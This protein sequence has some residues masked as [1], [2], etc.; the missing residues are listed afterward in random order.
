[1]NVYMFVFVR[2]LLFNVRC[3]LGFCPALQARQLR[4]YTILETNVNTFFQYF[5]FPE[6]LHFIRQP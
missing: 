4:Y 3:C 5:L 6:K 1:M 2:C